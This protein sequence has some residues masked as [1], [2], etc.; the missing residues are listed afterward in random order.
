MVKVS[1]SGLRGPGFDICVRLFSIYLMD[2]MSIPPMTCLTLKE[3]VKSLMVGRKTAIKKSPKWL[4]YKILS[5]FIHTFEIAKMAEI[6]IKYLL[7][8]IALQLVA[9]TILHFSN[10]KL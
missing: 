9:C 10:F 3:T 2:V 4:Y 8:F 6:R 7:C 5:L 1:D